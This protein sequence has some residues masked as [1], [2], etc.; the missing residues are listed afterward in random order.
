MWWFKDNKDAITVV[1]STLALLISISTFYRTW[2][3]DKRE[4]ADALRAKSPRITIQ[5]DRAN[6]EKLY[7]PLDR[8]FIPGWDFYVHLEIENRFGVS[9]TIQRISATE[10]G[11]ATVRLHNPISDGFRKHDENPTDLVGDTSGASFKPTK[12]EGM[13]RPS[14]HLHVGRVLTLE[15]VEDGIKID[16]KFDFE[17][18]DEA[19]KREIVVRQFIL[20]PGIVVPKRV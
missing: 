1:F 9:F 7:I 16:L 19:M 2:L 11:G 5:T 10:P 15:E 6:E 4:A 17:L 3:R 13:F 18:H 12:S 20:R 14:F 8:S